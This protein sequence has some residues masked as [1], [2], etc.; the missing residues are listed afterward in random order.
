MCACM[1][2]C[3][4]VFILQIHTH[5]P[6]PRHVAMFKCQYLHMSDRM[7]KRQTFELGVSG[8]VLAFKSDP[9][10]LEPEFP[11]VECRHGDYS[12]RPKWYLE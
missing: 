12:H 8:C 3:T 11:W 9:C 5:Y 1:C 6:C 10:L 7:E 2:V 4:C